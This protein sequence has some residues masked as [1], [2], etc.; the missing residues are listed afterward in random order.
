MKQIHKKIRKARKKIKKAHKFLTK[1]IKHT[2]FEFFELSV[3]GTIGYIIHIALLFLITEFFG[4]HYLISNAIGFF[5]GTSICFGIDKVVIFHEVFKKH[6]WKEYAEFIS[7]SITTLLLSTI[8][9]FTFTDL[10]G[11]YYIF[12]SILASALKSIVAYLGVKFWVFKGS[13]N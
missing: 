11:I 6:F 9:L 8:L 2:L 5:V 13:N 10:L 1:K 4:L 7:V 3:A 12:S